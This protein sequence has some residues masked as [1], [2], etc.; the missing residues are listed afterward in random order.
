LQQSI[1]LKNEI[2][3][4]YFTDEKTEAQKK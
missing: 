4:L 1:F 2:F 3:C